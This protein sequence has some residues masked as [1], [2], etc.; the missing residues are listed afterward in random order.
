MDD[1]LVQ[2]ALAGIYR[3]GSTNYFFRIDEGQRHQKISVSDQLLPLGLSHGRVAQIIAAFPFPV[4]RFHSEAMK[5]AE[6]TGERREKRHA[7][8]Q[9][10]LDEKELNDDDIAI[11]DEEELAP[12]KKKSNLQYSL[13]QRDDYYGC[14][15]GKD[16]TCVLFKTEQAAQEYLEEVTNGHQTYRLCYTNQHKG[17]I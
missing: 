13:V 3:S 14:Y 12:K 2:L 17:A 7:R 8:I 11:D 4:L 6:A 16:G 1:P 5:R 9:W 15:D 10:K